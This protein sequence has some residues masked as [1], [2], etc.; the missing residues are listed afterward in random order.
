MVITG[1]QGDLGLALC[2]IFLKQGAKIVLVCRNISP[3][4][5]VQS[6]KVSY[7]Q[8]DI[9]KDIGRK[10]DKIKECY[11]CF[12]DIDIWINNAGVISPNDL[13]G[14]FLHI[15][16]ADYDLQQDVNFKSIFFIT[17]GLSKVF[18][19]KKKS[20][21]IFNVLSIDGIRNTWQLYGLSKRKAIM[22]TETV[23]NEL[24]D[25]DIF[26]MGISPGG[27]YTRMIEKM[28]SGDSLRRNDVPDRRIAERSEVAQCIAFMCQNRQIF[29]GHVLIFDGGD[30]LN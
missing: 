12:G 17:Q 8:W 22:F 13:N 2:D 27:I 19:E 24:C 16:E 10:T 15:S 4:R 9:Q 5:M 3:E 23:A 6:D 25:Y 30:T 26:V 7:V 11:N 1:G 18:I 21:V 29:N 14:D 20:G 28:I